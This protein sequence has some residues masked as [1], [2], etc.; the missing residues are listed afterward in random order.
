MRREA[1]KR[2]AFQRLGGKLIRH[3]QYEAT[4]RLRRGKG[5]HVKPEVE[6]LDGKRALFTAAW[7]CDDDGY[8]GEMAMTCPADW[9][10]PWIASGDLCD[11]VAQ[12]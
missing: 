11:I 1:R 7:D 4:V 3:R 6:H 5:W 12:F 8:P 9:P 10:I 2:E